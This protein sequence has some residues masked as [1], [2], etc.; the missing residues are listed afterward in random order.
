VLLVHRRDVIE[1]IEIRH[2]LNV[3]FVF[4]EFFRAAMEQTDMRI[5]ALDDLAFH[6]KHKTQN[7]VRGRVLRP[8][9]HGVGTDLRFV[10][11]FCFGQCAHLSNFQRCFPRESGDL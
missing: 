6:F 2:G 8:E 11:D 5:G 4:Y 7:A 1:A 3:G 10:F 9:I